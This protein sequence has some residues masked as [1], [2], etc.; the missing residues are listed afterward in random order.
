MLVLIATYCRNI[1][2]Q[3][4]MSEQRN[5]ED[6]HLSSD[7]STP[8]T[9]NQSNCLS[10]QSPKRSKKA[11][12]SYRRRKHRRQLKLRS[13]NKRKLVALSSSAS[14]S[15]SHSSTDSD[16]AGSVSARRCKMNPSKGSSRP[17]T[18]SHFRKKVVAIFQ[19]HC[20]RL[21]TAFSSC[22]GT[23]SN[24]LFSKQIIS[25]EI[26]TKNLCSNEFDIKRAG[27]LVLCVQDWLDNHV[28]RWPELLQV[29]SEE[30]SLKSIIEEIEGEIE[31]C[32]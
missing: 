31:D 27:K 3:N 18:K 1:A 30:V 11:M 32:M 23:V 20:D 22:L 9:G 4:I 13:K 16:S 25:R 7:D 15:A 6:A 14:S 28:E 21:S 10:T 19:K 17:P 12:A 26:H 8:P 2:R 5:V 24:M 29:L